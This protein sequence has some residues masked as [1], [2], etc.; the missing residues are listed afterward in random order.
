MWFRFPGSGFRIELLILGLKAQSL[1]ACAH[2]DVCLYA[3]I[4]I[5]IC[6]CICIY[7]Y[8]YTCRYANFPIPIRAVPK[9]RKYRMRGTIQ[10]GDPQTVRGPNP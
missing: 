2:L 6:I 8:M 5:H 10:M 4:H 3:H 7:V 9:R 1:G